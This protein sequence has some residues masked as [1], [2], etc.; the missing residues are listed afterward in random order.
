MKALR[1]S[2]RR[3]RVQLSPGQLAA[4]SA[5]IAHSLWQ[6]PLLARCQRIACYMAIDG[7]VDCTGFMEAAVARGRR[8][9]LPVVHG[10]GL[11]FAAWHPGIPMA[12]NRYG[13]PEP[14]SDAATWLR[15]TQLDVVLA[16]LVAFD[17]GGRRLGM[18]GGY[19]DRSFAFTRQRGSWQRPRL[20]GL[21]HEFQCVASL[22]AR[23]WDVG[24]HA[25]VTEAGVRLF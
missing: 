19:Y 17:A 21:A 20:V 8:I 3:R 10:R 12:R 1:A 11:L 14:L 13:I 4:H 23:S 9:F 15:G 2:M 18:G 16:P 24:M 5:S 7:E 22:P 25:V 6:L